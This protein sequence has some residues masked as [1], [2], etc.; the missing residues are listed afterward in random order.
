MM[1]Y[2][3]LGIHL[4]ANVYGD[5]LVR[6]NWFDWSKRNKT[7]VYHT[8]CDI[9]L[10]LCHEITSEQNC[11][12]KNLGMGL[13]IAYILSMSSFACTLPP[14]QLCFMFLA[15]PFLHPSA[16]WGNV[17]ALCVETIVGVFLT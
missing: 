13:L 1:N 16:F 10:R 8:I 2:M 17:C 9:F 5:E 12:V 7:Y 15:L 14:S 4:V 3:Q 6:V 11:A